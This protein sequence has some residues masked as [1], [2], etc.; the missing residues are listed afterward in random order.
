VTS[1]SIAAETISVVVR[2]TRAAPSAEQRDRDVHQVHPHQHERHLERQ[3]ARALRRADVEHRGHDEAERA[4]HQHR[5]VDRQPPGVEP[6]FAI[7]DAAGDQRDAEAEQ[8]VRE[9]GARERC[10]DHRR[11]AV[12]KRDTANDQFGQVV[13]RRVQQ[14][15]EGGAEPGRQP[16]GGISDQADERDDGDQGRREDRRR[17]RLVPCQA[18]CQGHRGEEPAWRHAD[19]RAVAD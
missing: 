15:P 11:Q 6:L 10:L 12:G 13:E 18:E 3:V 2:Q 9:D 16:F 8:K 19:L 7:A 4:D 17:G 14:A 1:P 5:S